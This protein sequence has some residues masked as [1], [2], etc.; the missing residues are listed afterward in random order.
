MKTIYSTRGAAKEYCE[1]AIDIYTGC[2]HSCEYCYAKASATRKNLDFTDIKVRN[3]VL[4]ETKTFLD[5]HAEYHGKTIFLGF[6]SDPFPTGYDT[7]ATVEMIKLLK[8]YGC[9][10]MFCTK[11]KINPKVIDLLD[12][13]DS[14]GITITCGNEMASIYESKSI[15]PTERLAQLEAFYNKDIETWISIEPV[16]EPEFIYEMLESDNMKFITKVKLGKLNHMDLSDL[17]GNTNDNINW[18]KYGNK[19]I[20]ICKRRNIEYIVKYALTKFL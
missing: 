5:T 16:L 3:N 9:H 10:I 6:S 17:T 1:Y 11:G 15:T 2:P 18:T 13:N 19:V 7:S 20:E 8:N 12:S 4:E 14:V